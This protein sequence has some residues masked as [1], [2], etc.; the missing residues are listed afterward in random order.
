VGLYAEGMSCFY[1]YEGNIFLDVFCYFRQGDV[2][3]STVTPEGHVFIGDVVRCCFL[4]VHGGCSFDVE[5]PQSEGDLWYFPA[6]NPHS[7][8]AKNTTCGAEFLLIF[9]SGYFSEDATFL[10]TDWLAHVPK[11]VLAKNFGI[12]DLHA[13][14]HIPEKELYIFPCELRP[15]P[16]WQLVFLT[17]ILFR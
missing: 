12:Q 8:Q 17:R 5:L 16:Y 15:Y 7:I 6:G 14:D 9:D 2:R 3:I 10:L 11:G 1:I 4:D 13:F